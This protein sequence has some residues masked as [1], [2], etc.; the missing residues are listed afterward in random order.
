MRCASSRITWQGSSRF[1][2]DYDVWLTRTLA[3]PPLPIS[4]PG[5]DPAQLAARDAA[6]T[7]TTASV[8]N[9]TGNPAMSVPL[10]WNDGQR[11]I[12]VDFLVEVSLRTPRSCRRGR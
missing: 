2:A 7:A 9:I 5:A 8:A 6:F 3:Q 4:E 1:L 10:H 12:G 11:P